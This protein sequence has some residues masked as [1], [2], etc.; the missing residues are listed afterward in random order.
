MDFH[1]FKIYCNY[2]KKQA[3]VKLKLDLTL[4][5]LF[6]GA[7]LKKNSS[8]QSWAWWGEIVLKSS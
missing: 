7:F 4:A 8:K 3:F 5:F 6:K 1:N 2:R